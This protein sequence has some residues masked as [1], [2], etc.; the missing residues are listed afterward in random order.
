MGLL[1]VVVEL[2]APVALVNRRWATGWTIAAWT[3]HVGIVALMW[4]SFAYP[5]S[6]IAF[7]PFFR[8]ERPVEWFLDR[9]DVRTLTP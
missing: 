1:T 7:A 8:C 6:L 5:L 2:G 4:I 9:R 3:F